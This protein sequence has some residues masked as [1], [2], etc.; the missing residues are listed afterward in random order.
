MQQMPT[1]RPQCSR[2]QG[3]AGHATTAHTYAPKPL[4]PP[5]TH[6][7]AAEHQQRSSP[8]G[9]HPR[10][11]LCKH[12]TSTSPSSAVSARRA[13]CPTVHLA[14]PQ[15]PQHTFRC[16]HRRVQRGTLQCRRQR[17]AL[18]RLC[19]C[20]LSAADDLPCPC[21]GAAVGEEPPNMD[22]LDACRLARAFIRGAP[23]AAAAALIRVPG[24]SVAPAPPFAPTS[25]SDVSSRLL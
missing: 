22:A 15:P 9:V 11:G 23:F 24:P 12:H 10:Q 3:Y 13:P 25:R 8:G 20:S 4:T 16:M 14:V 7:P 19:G 1:R 5:P 17:A 21:G 18:R 6:A 2:S